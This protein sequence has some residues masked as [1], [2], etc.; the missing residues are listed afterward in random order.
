MAYRYLKQ[1]INMQQDYANNHVIAN[2]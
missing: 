1:I 2:K